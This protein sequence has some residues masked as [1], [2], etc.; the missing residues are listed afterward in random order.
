MSNVLSRQTGRCGVLCEVFSQNHDKGMTIWC[1]WGHV[2]G[3]ARLA[4]MLTFGMV[5]TQIFVIELPT[6]K[7]LP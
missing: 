7:H 6:F 2:S 5:V 4:L 3:Q 1:V